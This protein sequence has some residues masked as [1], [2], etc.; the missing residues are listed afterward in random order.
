MFFC[1]NFNFFFMKNIFLILFVLFSFFTFSFSQ[2]KGATMSFDKEVHD[3]GL[4][5]TIMV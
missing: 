2:Q 5:N 3:Y 4:I 1:K